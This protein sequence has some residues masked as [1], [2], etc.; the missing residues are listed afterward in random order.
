MALKRLT[1]TRGDYQTY[2]VVFKQADGSLYN[3]KNW[4]VHFTLKTN[5]SLPDASAS[6]QKIVTTFSDTT[7]G[8]S[9]SANIVLNPSDTVNLDPGEYDFDIAVTTNVSQIFTVVKGKFVLEYD[10]T[11]SVGTAGT[12]A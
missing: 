7:A 5:W 2:G 9:G 11:R 12:A 1:M 10:V 8:T 4:V 3:I 6:L